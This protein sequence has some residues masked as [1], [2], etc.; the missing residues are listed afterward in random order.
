[1]DYLTFVWSFL[2][3]LTAFVCFI[4]ARKDVRRGWTFLGLTFLSAGLLRSWQFFW[5]GDPAPMHSQWIPSALFIIASLCAWEAAR[6]FALRKPS[7]AWMILPVLIAVVSWVALGPEFFVAQAQWWLWAPALLVAAFSVFSVARLE[8]GEVRSSG[9]LLAGGMVIL[10]IMKP[11]PSVYSPTSHAHEETLNALL[12]SPQLLPALLTTIACAFLLAGSWITCRL[13]RMSQITANPPS[14]LRRGWIFGFL[15]S[16]V[17]MAGWPVTDRISEQ[18]DREWREQL[19]QETM[20][21]ASSIL[22]QWVTGLTGTPADVGS[23]YYEVVKNRLAQVAVAGRGYRMATLTALRDGQVIFLADSEPGGSREESIAGDVYVDAFQELIA[24]FQ[25]PRAFAVGPA[26]DRWGTWVSGFAPLHGTL[27]AGKPVFLGLDLGARLWTVRLARLRQARMLAILVFALFL[28]GSFAVNYVTLEAKVLQ[29]VSEDRLRV[30]LQGAELAAWEM[31]LP[32][33]VLTLDNAWRNLSGIPDGPTVLDCDDFLDLVHPE[34]R[35]IARRGF[36][37]HATSSVENRDCEFRI[38]KDSHHWIWVLNRG[39][40]IAAGTQWTNQRAAGLLLDISVRK[41]TETELARQRAEAERLALV[42]ENTTNAVIIT[43][44]EGKIEWVN[45]GFTRLTGYVFEEIVGRRPGELLQGTKS[46]LE[47]IERM[48]QAIHSGQG[49]SETLINY[50]KSGIPYWVEIECQPLHNAEGDLTG[51]MAI[52]ADVSPRIEAERALEEQRRRLQVINECLLGLGDNY[53]HNLQELTVLAATVFHADRALYHRSNPD[54]VQLMTGFGVDVKTT[55]APTA[56]P[57]L[58]IA[59]IHHSEHFV[60][61]ENLAG[62]PAALTDPLATGFTTFVG[63]GVD[64]AGEAIGSLGLLFRN[65]FRLTSDLKDCLS[66][67]AQAVGREELLQ[68]NRLSLDALASREATE[69]SRFSTLLLNMEDAV[70]VEDANRTITFANPSLEKM[71][72]VSADQLLGLPSPVLIERLRARF[73]EAHAFADSLMAAFRDARPSTGQIFEMCDGRYIFR[74]FIPIRDSEISYG[75]LWHF[76]D[77]SRQRRNQI[78][79]E[80]VA[81]VGESVLRTALNSS[82]AWTALSGTLGTKIGVDRILVYEVAPGTAS[83]SKLSEWVHE[84]SEADRMPGEFLPQWADELRGGHPVV[85]SDP[86]AA[87]LKDFHCRTILL[88]PLFVNKSLWGAIMLQHSAISHAWHENEI[89]L[90]AAA[91]SLISSRMDLQRSEEALIAAKEAADQANRAKSTFLATMSHEIRTPLNAVIGL[92]SLLLE[93]RLDPVQRDYASTVTT[94]AQTLLEL[95]SDILDYSKIEAGRIEIEHLPLTLR[96]VVD[97]ALD[98]LAPTAKEKGLT[99]SSEVAA[100]LPEVVLGDRTRLKQILLNLLS[101]AVKFTESGSVSVSVEPDQAVE[102]GVRFTVKD[103]GIG[104]AKDQIQHIFEP[105]MQADSSITR[106][107]GGTGLGL[108][109]SQRLILLMNGFMDVSSEKGKGST[110]RFTLPMNPGQLAESAPDERGPAA[111]RL[112]VLVA[113]DNATNQK[114]I[115][116]MLKRLDI[117]P[118]IVPNGL[119]ALERVKSEPFDLVLMDVQMAVMDGLASARAMRAHFGDGPRPEIIALTANAF[120]EDREACLAAGMDG[121]L[122]KPLTMDK[123]KAVIEGTKS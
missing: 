98:I 118:T 100:D 99:L 4:P 117:T 8:T 18:M 36:F 3:C 6:R 75:Y 111:E 93:T 112:R 26:S 80:A 69:R 89:A 25:N 88:L 66:I 27:W 57:A 39:K 81:D 59:V 123:L 12:R 72:D 51:F 101:N 49:F 109:I 78:L 105:F 5:C 7:A 32:S 41:Q 33:R 113:E 90:L 44:A 79:L 29:D 97:E 103:T 87:S 120:K 71:F 53:E 102:N 122:V 20:L 62:H 91:A 48:R 35:E 63:M 46:A 54:G 84:G 38:R 55:K 65:P 9:M 28:V 17:L 21:A 107:F 115:N 76:R 95:I 42:A 40:K 110:F 64:M 61:I 30:S 45:S 106:R 22:P 108:P 37:G 23:P 10:A 2:L 43:S 70:L 114:V 56:S 52:E 82:E 19:V 67:I 94:S 104:I 73:V 58:G 68:K 16:G 50:T 92:S 86:Q 47:V 96:E 121:Y 85:V 116:L 24:A 11:M 1:M 77:I 15:V 13:S 119:L 60:V 83:F 14:G 31:D 74:D 34:D